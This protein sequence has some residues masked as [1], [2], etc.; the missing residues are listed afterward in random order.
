MPLVSDIDIKC[1][2]ARTASAVAAF[3]DVQEQGILSFGASPSA[4]TSTTATN[5]SMGTIPAG[6]Y[7]L[8]GKGIF[9]LTGAT[10]TGRTISIRFASADQFTSSS[11]GATTTATTTE[12]LDVTGIYTFTSDTSVV[13]RAVATFSAGSITAAGSLLAVRLY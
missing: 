9:S 3:Q 4:L 10:S 8:S 6:T 5:L 12:V 2:L 11:V 7:V 1:C 13:L